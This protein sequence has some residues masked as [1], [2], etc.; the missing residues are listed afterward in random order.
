MTLLRFFRANPSTRDIP[1][2]VLSSKM[3]ALVEI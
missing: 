2:V 3:L 1:V